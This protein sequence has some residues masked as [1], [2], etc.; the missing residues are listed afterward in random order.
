MLARVNLYPNNATRPSRYSVDLNGYY[1]FT[2][3]HN[4][5]LRLNLAVYNLLD[6]LNE[7]NVNAQTGRAYTAII[8]P[9]QIAGY[10]SNF[11][12]Y[13][14]TVHDPSMYSTPR[15]VKLGLGIVF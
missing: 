15:L 1:D 4:L 14:D 7:E 6:R 3:M 11:S 12:E 9:T 13:I 5:K 10:R 2:I 8:R